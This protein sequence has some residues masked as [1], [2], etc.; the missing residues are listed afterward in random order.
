MFHLAYG[1]RQK[2]EAVKE[3]GAWNWLTT[4]ATKTGFIFNKQMFTNVVGLR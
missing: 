4:L 1:M 2:I 3:T